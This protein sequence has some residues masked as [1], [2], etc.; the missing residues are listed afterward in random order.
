MMIYR[1]TKANIRSLNEDT[2]S[3][4]IVDGVLQGDTQAPNLFVICQNSILLIDLI[5]ENGFMVKKARSRGYPAETIM[6]AMIEHFL[7]I[8]HHKLNPYCIALE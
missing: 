8:H 7:Q 1:N 4:N 3:F 5:K 2:D 6:D